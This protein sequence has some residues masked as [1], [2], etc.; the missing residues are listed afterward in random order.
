MFRFTK[1]E[2]LCSRK[3]IE[4]LYTKG[5]AKNIFPFRVIVIKSDPEKHLNKEKYPARFMISVPKKRIKLAVKRNRVKRLVREAWRLNKHKL[6]AELLKKNAHCDVMLVYI[7]SDLPELKGV[8]NKM[9][10]V[11]NFIV[12][13]I[14]RD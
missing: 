9:P 11:F 8:E 2:R 1:Q 5:K 3:A 14:T 4:I 12:G 7:T 6:Y 10:A 13:E